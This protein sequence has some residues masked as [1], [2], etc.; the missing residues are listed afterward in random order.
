MDIQMGKPSKI[1]MSL[2]FW[3][4]HLNIF[5]IS[6]HRENIYGNRGEGEYL[7]KRMCVY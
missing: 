2:G 5:G 6:E 7:G 4:T 3:E 1:S